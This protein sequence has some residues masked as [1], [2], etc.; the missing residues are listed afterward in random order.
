VPVITTVGVVIVN[1]NAGNHLVDCVAS[2]RAEGISD[3]VVVDNGS[4]DGSADALLAADPEVKLLHLDNPGL[5]A[6]VNRG[7]HELR[8]DV[9]FCLN[10]DAIV[11]PGAIKTLTTALES[12]DGVAMVGPRLLNVDGS[13]YPSARSFPQLSHAIGHAVMSL[14]KPNN[15]WTRRYKRLDEN[16]E[17]AH[18]VDWVSG[19]AMFV[20]RSA[21]DEVNG[22]DPAYFL[23]MEDVDLC[24]RLHNA[25]WSVVY[26]PAAIVT[27][28]QGVSTGKTPYRTLRSHHRSAIKYN[29]RT[30]QGFERLL[31]PVVVAGLAARLPAAWIHRYITTSWRSPA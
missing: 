2:V 8:T 15:R 30:A 19:A 23:Y 16:Y 28:V 20:R 25:G 7:T 1:Y 22:F 31:L 27:H 13:I 14:M 21:F 29:V 3:L 11:H 17:V 24:W 18:E 10:P 4:T 6:A 5:G 26:E 12:D 9:V